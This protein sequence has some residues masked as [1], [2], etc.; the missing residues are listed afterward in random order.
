MSSFQPGLPSVPGVPSQP[1]QLQ[2]G[3]L[4]ASPSH[5]DTV[6]WQALAQS[7]ANNYG[8]PHVLNAGMRDM[9]Y[10]ATLLVDGVGNQATFL[11]YNTNLA[12]DTRTRQ[13]TGRFYRNTYTNQC[14]Y[15]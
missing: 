15:E 8:P 10:P 3:A 13:F 1:T 14:C 9:V 2:V 7:Y 6:T 12:P 4:C 11:S 5:I